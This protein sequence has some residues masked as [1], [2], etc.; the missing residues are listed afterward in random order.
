[1]TWLTL[2]LIAAFL[3]SMSALSEKE[4]LTKEDFRIYTSAFSLVIAFLSLPLMFFVGDFNLSSF[5][6]LLIFIA[7]LVSVVSS[8]TAAYSMQKLDIG[9]SSALFALSPLLVTLLAVAFLHESLAAM[10]VAGIALSALGVYV[11]EH[12]F[13]HHLEVNILPKSQLALAA[14][15]SEKISQKKKWLTYAL[16][17]V[18]L[19]FFS[20]GSI[21][22]RYIIHDQGVNPLLYLV[23]VQFFLLFN[24]IIYDLASIK[25]MRGKIV[26]PRL[27]LRFSF[28]VN[29]IV[30]I[31]HRVVHSLAVGMIEI[32]ILNAV[33]QISAVFTT[34][35]GGTFFTEKH[36]L[37]RAL[38]CT[39]I[40]AGVLIVVLWR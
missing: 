12:R 18:S 13:S 3:K 4:V 23:I 8:V 36:R 27:F 34:I 15:N 10:Q 33:K 24:L 14:K 37:K 29:I 30:I 26:N 2:A 9:E 7:S 11:L 31:C 39:L 17:A 5:D 28:W 35:I 19:V 1:M 25:K 38:G 40:T 32:S 20:I 16:L 21:T 6:V 22:D